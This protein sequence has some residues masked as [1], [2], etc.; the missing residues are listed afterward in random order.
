LSAVV[1]ASLLVAALIDNGP[2]GTWAEE[3]IVR[4]GL[5]APEIARVETVNILR[6]LELAKQ[7]T[8]AEASAACED[9]MRL[10]FELYPFGPFADRVWSLRHTVTCYD[11]WYIALAE[12]LDLPL[13][14]LDG[15]LAKSRGPR[16]RFLAPHGH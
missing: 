2:H 9:F 4:G 15:R 11:G 14:T 5:H 13:A 10:P 3:V 6:R 16:C 8:G 1:D 7:I 12:A